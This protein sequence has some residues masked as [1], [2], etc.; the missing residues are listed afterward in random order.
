M[1]ATAVEATCPECGHA[2][3]YYPSAKNYYCPKKKGGCGGT[4]GRSGEY[5]PY[6]Y[7][8]P[9]TPC[10][11]CGKPGTGK[12]CRS[13]N[14]WVSRCGQDGCEEKWVHV[15]LSVRTC[16]YPSCDQVYVTRSNSDPSRERQWCSDRCSR[17]HHKLEYEKRRGMASRSESRETRKKRGR[18]SFD[19]LSLQ[20]LVMQGYRC[21][22]CDEVIDVSLPH[23][24]PMALTLDHTV[25]L[26]NGGSDDPTNLTAMHRKCNSSKGAR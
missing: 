16:R 4:V 20:L 19:L 5:T 7:T 25:A 9:K 6:L 17:N 14:K 2:L 1:T 22:W 24:D 11:L 26:A 10:S 8:A 3:V 13:C 23:K 15:H 18:V 12:T 21:S